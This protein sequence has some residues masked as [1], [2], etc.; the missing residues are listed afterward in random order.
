MG[1][2]LDLRRMPKKEIEARVLEA[3]KIL[4]MKHLRD[5]RPAAL[6]GGQRQRVAIGRAYCS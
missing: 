3:A 2:S 6:S 1:F 4:Q 5:R